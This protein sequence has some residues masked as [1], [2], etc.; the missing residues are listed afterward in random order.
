MRKIGVMGAGSW[1][2]ALANLLSD[3]GFQ[4]YLWGRR[5]DGIEEMQQ[6]RE[7]MQYLPG[8][9]LADTVYPTDD[10]EQAVADAEMIVMAVPSQAVREVL[11]KIKP[12]LGARAYVLIASKGLEIS[13]GKRLSQVTEEVI[14]S[15]IHGLCA[16]LAGPTHAEEVARKLP[17]AAVVAAYLDNTAFAIQDMFMCRYFRVYTNPDVLGVELGSAMKNIFALATGI[18]RGLGYGDNSSAALITRGLA[19]MLRMGKKLGGVSKTFS[20]LSGLGDL[21][22]TCTSTYSRNMR[23]GLLVAQGL[24][25]PQVQ[26]QIGMVVEG[27]SAVQII[28]RLAE[29]H[30]IDMPICSACYSILF[31]SADLRAAVDRLMLREK[32]REVEDF[33]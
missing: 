28:N 19:E 30:K 2:T 1:G 21:V 6:Q 5:E 24:Q 33:I 8:I 32:K 22:V 16:V 20:G 27:I 18:L 13:T 17:S 3:N 23:A 11:M 31:E 4:V 15:H 29:E 7:N 10:I 14:G 26:E 12:F 9:P 25:I